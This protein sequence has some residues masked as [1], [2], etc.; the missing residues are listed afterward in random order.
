MKRSLKILLILLVVGG[1]PAGSYKSAMKYWKERNRPKWRF[2]EVTKGDIVSDV[3]TTGQVKPVL[4]VR[5]GAVVSGPIDK[6]FA[7]FNDKVKKGDLLATIDKRIYDS[8]VKSAEA[9]LNIRHAD[10]RRAE[11]MLYQSLNDEYRALALQRE[12]SRF[13]SQAE[14]DQLRFKRESLEAEVA[15]AAAAVEQAKANLKNA[16]AN[17]EYTEILSPVDGIVIDRKID[18]GQALAAQFQAPELFIV[19]TDLRKEVRIFAS[20]DET[21]IGLIREAQET[22]K[23]VCFTV[24]AYPDDLFEGVIY[25]IRLSSLQTQNVVTYPVVVSASNPD[26]KLLPGMTASVSFR[27]DERHDVVKIP[28]AALRFYP[29]AKHVREED[30]KLLEGAAWENEDDD[31]LDTVLSAEERAEVRRKRNRRHVWVVEGDF[32]KA[33]EVEIDLSDS[34]FSEMASGDLEEGQKLVIGIDT[35]KK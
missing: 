22:G 33:M 15:V 23:P 32:L 1:I 16:D 27:V 20:V 34:K 14:L 28:N 2:A 35:T 12:S 6:L 19:A 11:S 21:D 29:E 13:I 3:N 9:S 26:M 30:K 8:A 10:V 18:E 7:D 25:E 5:V 24:D 17:L 31:G 4:S